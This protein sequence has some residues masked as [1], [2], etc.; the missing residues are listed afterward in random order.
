MSLQKKIKDD[1]KTAMI[2]RDSVSLITLRGIANALTI[3]LDAQKRPVSDELSDEDTIRILQRLVKQRKDSIEQFTKGE[4]PDLV[5]S[6]SAE[7]AIIEKY[8]PA[9]MTKEDIKKIAEA[10]KVE[11]GITDKTQVGKLMST[12]MKDL[13]GKANGSDVKEVVEGL[14]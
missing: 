13:R 1:I 10:K 6:E 14:F 8:V 2:A 11:M 4:R 3:E 7:L 12:L 9:M 5:A